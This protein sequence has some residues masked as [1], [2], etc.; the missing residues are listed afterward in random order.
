VFYPAFRRVRDS[1]A[2][3]GPPYLRVVAAYTGVTWPAMA[4]IAVLAGPLVDLLYGTHWHAAAPLLAWIA[5]GQLCFVAVP[6]YADL[7]ILLGRMNGM[8]RRLALDTLASLALLALA[9]PHGLGWIAASR[10][11]HGIVFVAIYAPFLRSMV[12][13]RWRDLVHIYGQSMAAAAA[14]VTPLLASYALWQG[15]DEVGLV[16]AGGG[17]LAGV[18]CW[19]AALALLR[20][21]LFDEI[22]A[23]LGEGRRAFPSLR[24]PRALS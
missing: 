8:L 14:A 3:L 12:G 11:A 5:L 15:P 7:P 4:G 23:L 1:G 24:T 13:F 16:Q 21:P 10:L 2:P 22:L 18:G 6:L 17:V 9:A 20:H 19:L